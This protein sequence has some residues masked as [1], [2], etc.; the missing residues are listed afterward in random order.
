VSPVLKVDGLTTGYLRAPVLRDV[1][2]EV[3]D[4]IVALFGANGAGKT[5]LLR[6]I[7]GALPAWK[8]TVVLGG[9]TLGRSRPWR[10]VRLGVAHVPEGRHVFTAMT[11]KEN[12]DVA[13]L[14]GRHA[15]QTRDEVFELFPRLAERRDQRAGSLSGGEQQMLAI[16]RALMTEPRLL[17]LDEMSA[18]LAPIMVQTLAEGLRAV[19]ERGISILLVEQ[20]PHVVADLADRVYVLDRGTVTAEGTV[21]EIGGADHLA[22][23]Y[24]ATG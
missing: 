5:T 6:A 11:V 7:A 14:A 18:G 4:E 1:S 17:L 2:L 13:G 8:G 9:R 3:G 10:R 20:T 24:L 19:H 16:G 15:R 23:V 12:L 22:S 21:A